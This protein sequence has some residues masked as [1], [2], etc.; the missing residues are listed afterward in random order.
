MQHKQTNRQTKKQKLTQ[1]KQT[2]K[3]MQQTLAKTRSRGQSD[4]QLPDIQLPDIQLRQFS[5]CDNQ[6]L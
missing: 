3:Q 2:N 5:F 1:L 6:L 4:I